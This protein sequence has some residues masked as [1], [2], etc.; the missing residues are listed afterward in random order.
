MIEE[1][2]SDS[3]QHYFRGGKLMPNG[4]RQDLFSNNKLRDMNDSCSW[5]PYNNCRGDQWLL[6]PGS[7]RPCPILLC[8]AELLYNRTGMQGRNRLEFGD[9]YAPIMASSRC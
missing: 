1:H 3:R 2:S 6:L 9:L 7:G 5:K 4:W 8:E